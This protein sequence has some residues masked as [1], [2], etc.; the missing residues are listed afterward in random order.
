ME[1]VMGYVGTRDLADM[2]EQD[3]R[4]LDVINIA[5]AHMK[6][7]AVV[8]EAGD[9]TVK[10]ALKR[11]RE[12]HPQLKLVLSIGGWSADGFSQAARSAEGRARMADTAAALAEEYGLDGIDVDWEYPGTSL[13]GIAS[14][15][16]DKENFV[17]ILQALRQKLNTLGEGKLLTI[18]VGG[19]AYYTV[20]LDMR[21]VCECL[22]YVQLMTYDLQGGF[23]NVTGH[24]AALY[25]G[26]LNLFDV[27]VDKAVRVFSEAGVPAEKLVVG[28]PFYSREWRGVKAPEGS[29]GLGIEAETV[30]GYGPAYKDLVADYIGKNGF[31]RYWDEEAK[32]PYL[33]DGSTFISYEDTESAAGKAAYVK[34]KK[35]AGVMFWEYIQDLDGTLLNCLRETIDRA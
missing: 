22:D 24:H 4:S 33:F 28:V 23:Q 3:I 26:R 15:P 18:A 30:G 34:E 27:C 6:D 7:N 11:I 8:W 2:R 25:H 20:G 31:V 13:A 14:H 12:I 29:S 19:D 17:R 1:K 9:D 5:F 35:L 32:A 16:D 21:A 10:A